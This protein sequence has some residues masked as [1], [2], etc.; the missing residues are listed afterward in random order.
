MRKAK[1]KRCRNCRCLFV[2]DP[3]KKEKHYYC[4][5]PEC[6]KAS[7]TASQKKWLTKP[8]NRNYFRGPDNVKRVQRWR[9]KNPGYWKRPKK[10]VALQDQLLSQAFE[11]IGNNDKL[12]T[13]ALQDL[14]TAQPPVIIGL[15]ANLTGTT[16]QDEI[17]ST[18]VRMQQSGQDI[19]CLQPK[20][21][22]EDHDCKI[23]NFE[24][25]GP[26]SPKKLQLGRSP[27]G[28]R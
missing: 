18:L 10:S 23:T 13:T 2:A 12:E 24:K 4:T 19:L 20:M 28:E 17:A 22:G 8:E 25:P 21:R 27:T 26:Q 3:R 11:T 7:K 9:K 14:L 1:K 15:I 6:R 16:L 5:K